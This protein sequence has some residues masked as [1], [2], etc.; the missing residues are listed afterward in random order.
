M[1]NKTIERLDFQFEN[2]Q[3]YVDQ[4]FRFLH[5]RNLIPY[6]IDTER[7]GDIIHTVKKQPEN[8][9][10]S[11]LGSLNMAFHTEVPQEENNPDY[12][13]I[14]CITGQK[15]VFT[16]VVELDLIIES[17]D[18]TCVN[19]LLSE[20][21][22]IVPNASFEDR[23]PK[24][25]RLLYLDSEKNFCVRGNLGHIT[26]TTPETERALRDFNSALNGVFKHTVEFTEKGQS[27]LI[28]NKRTMH[29]RRGDISNNERE[30]KRIYLKII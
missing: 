14:T 19:T 7:K 10:A 28:D 20:D 3:Q 21:V 26:H 27:V 13:L 4:V 25:I 1:T 22:V 17:M 16:D 5:S 11:S 24:R 29:N 23:E 9:S 15:G 2:N 12:T 30:L 6:A 8:N 18:W